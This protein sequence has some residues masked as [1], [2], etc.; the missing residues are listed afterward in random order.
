[1][2]AFVAGIV[3]MGVVV[4]DAMDLARRIDEM[5]KSQTLIQLQLANSLG[6][7]LVLTFFGGLGGS[8]AAAASGAHTRPPAVETFY[9]CSECGTEIGKTEA[10]CGNCGAAFD[11]SRRR[12]SRA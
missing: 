8:I 5:N 6:A 12:Y 10:Y 3:V 11:A 4:I 9:R 2:L 1:M 7:G